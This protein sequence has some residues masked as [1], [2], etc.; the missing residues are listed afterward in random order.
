[1]AAGALHGLTVLV[2]RP[3]GLG[4][5]L[6]AAIRELGGEALLLPALAIEPLRPG[7][8]VLAE[9]AEAPS[10]SLI[11]F[12][13]RNAVAWGARYLPQPRP[14]VAAIGPSTARALEELGLKPN[15]LPDGWTTESL[16]AQP[17]LSNLAGVRVY[18]I[19]GE[20]GREALAEGLAERGARVRY[21]EVYRR[22]P[23]PL[24]A[25]RRAEVLELWRT[26]GIHAYTATSVEVF[27][28]LGVLLGPEGAPLLRST[29]LVTAS[30]RVLQMAERSGHS[31]ARLMAAGPDDRSLVEALARW[32]T[33]G[34]SG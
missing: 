26:G 4:D 32:R 33:M 13:S 20:G 11:I 19:R 28:N 15:V 10:G 5:Q 14:R 8:S 31:A 25:A 21:L 17:E 12:V 27:R 18:I 1:M 24:P 34:G 22:R 9:L 6:L 30:E 3:Q 29:P 23:A 2:T 16:L 7:T